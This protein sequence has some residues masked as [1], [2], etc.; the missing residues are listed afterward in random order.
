[1]MNKTQF[2]AIESALNDVG[3]FSYSGLNEQQKV[4]L[5]LIYRKLWNALC[6]CEDGSLSSLGDAAIRHGLLDE[7]IESFNN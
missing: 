2:K 7:E 6:E 5:E 4:K 3:S 1:M